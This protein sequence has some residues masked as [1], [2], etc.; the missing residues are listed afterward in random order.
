MI[1]QS[2][3]RF[4]LNFLHSKVFLLSSTRS[5]LLGKINGHKLDGAKIFSMQ[6]LPEREGCLVH[7]QA[8]QE[9]IRRELNGCDEV[10]RRLCLKA[11]FHSSA[12][13]VHV[14]RYVPSD[15]QSPPVDRNVFQRK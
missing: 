2:Y 14:H 9:G 3:N 4:I 12:K 5:V 10:Q 7:L 8:H 6:G 11:D 13:E 1:A 15:H